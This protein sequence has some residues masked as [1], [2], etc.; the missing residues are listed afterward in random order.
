MFADQLD[1]TLEQIE[2]VWKQDAE[3][4]I[5]ETPLRN[6]EYDKSDSRVAVNIFVCV[7]S[8]RTVTE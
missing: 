3:M 4:M 5:R 7:V 8:Y 2:K 6:E 1:W